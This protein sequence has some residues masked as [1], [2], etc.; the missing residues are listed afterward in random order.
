MK[1]EAIFYALNRS[2]LPTLV[3]AIIALF[4]TLS[5]VEVFNF[6]TSKTTGSAILRITM[7]IV[8]IVW[9]AFLYKTKNDELIINEEVNNEANFTDYNKNRSRINELLIGI[10]DNL[11]Y[12]QRDKYALKYLKDQKCLIIKHL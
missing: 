12:E 11:N 10:D 6:L 4:W 2:L 3:I 5:F 7:L 1:K 8:E 9:F